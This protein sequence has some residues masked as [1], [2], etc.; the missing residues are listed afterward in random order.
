MLHIVPG[1]LADPRVVALLR[2]HTTRALAE[3]ARGSGHALDHTGLQ[4]PDIQFFA[5]WMDDALH[6]IGALKHLDATTGEIKSM[7]TAEAA[8]RTGAGR[9][10]LTHLIATARAAGMT[11]LFLE[12]GSWPYFK[13]AV[14]FYRA[15][16][17]VPCPPFGDYQPDPNS[18]FL[19]LDL[20]A[21]R[22]P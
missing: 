22:Q 3:T 5:G 12:T 4:R 9:A 7:H 2:I 21:G 19:T 10:M 8:R 20:A 17:F 13:P 16:G 15:H 11:R 14:A 18:L 1:H 6:V